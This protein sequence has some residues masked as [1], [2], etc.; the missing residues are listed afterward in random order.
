MICIFSFINRHLSPNS[1]S[2]QI[3]FLKEKYIYLFIL[4]LLLLL[5]LF[6]ATPT[7][8]GNSQARH[9]IGATAAG[10]CHSNTGSEPHVWS[11][12]IAQVNTLSLTHWPGIEPTSLWILVWFVTHWATMETPR[13]IPLDFLFFF[14]FL[15]PRLQHMEVPQLG[16][17]RCSY[18]PMP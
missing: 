16:V 2:S 17:Q 8:Y 12:P 3:L 6:R 13:E 10:L 4:L 14:F 7:E 1:N 11:T 9:W 5:L 18:R 15:Q